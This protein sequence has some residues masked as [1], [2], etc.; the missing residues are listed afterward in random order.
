[1]TEIIY[2]DYN[3]TTPPRPEV[4]EAMMEVLRVAG[5]ASAVHASGRAARARVE[6]AR[7]SISALIGAEPSQIIFT[8]SGTESNNQALRG[9]GRKRIIVSAI[10]HEAVR[11]ARADAETVPVKNNGII[12]LGELDRMLGASEEPAQ[13]AVML[14]NNETGVIQP[15]ADVSS[16][17]HR[18]G[19]LVH[20]DAVQ[21]AG[22]IPVDV[23]ALGADS[24]ALS[25]HKFAGPQGVGVLVMRTPDSIGRFVHGGGQERGLRAGTEN[26]AGIVGLGVAAALAAEALPKYAKLADL[27]DDLERRLRDI[28]PDMIV[29]GQASERLPNTSKMTM[30]G[31]PSD[32]QV[33]AMDLA[34]IAISAGSA[35]A[36]GKVEPP[37]VLSA[38]GVPDDIAITATR[39]SL[40][41]RTR[42][43]DLD[44]F[45]ATWEKLYR[46]LGK[47]AA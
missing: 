42:P 7:A 24:Y 41:W 44:A 2:C 34:G 9:S 12:N 26:V 43:E 21:A 22:K 33:M 29:F 35:C 40:G 13:V 27:R 47:K 37:Y 11:S 5:N 45:V 32:T 16:I 28:A 6:D 14:A 39:V 20:C 15:I 1:M 4:A 23:A 46:R 18:Y 17:A 25:S 3:A 36:A 38:M 31:V 8:G 10:E 19:A 30:P